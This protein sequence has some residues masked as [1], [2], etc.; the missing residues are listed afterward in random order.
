VGDEARDNRDWASAAKAYESALAASSTLA[1][2]W[3]QLG[4]ARKESGALESAEQAYRAALKL[5]PD[6]ADSH[7]QLGHL[8]KMS[9]RKAEAIACYR[10]AAETVEG[11]N[12]ALR[13]LA[14][15]GISGRDL[16]FRRVENLAT[17]GFGEFTQGP[18]VCDVTAY[19]NA[20]QAGREPSLP[21]NRDWRLALGLQELGLA[22]PAV[23]ATE[24]GPYKALRAVG[25]R[26]DRES[27]VETLD[28]GSDCAPGTVIITTVADAPETP[29]GALSLRAG[30]QKHAY[31]I[32]VL[33]PDLLPGLANS[34]GSDTATYGRAA[35]ASLIYVADFECEREWRRRLTPIGRHP[36]IKVLRVST[37]T[38]SQT[39]PA[40][41]ARRV[42]CLRPE[43]E[44]ETLA[45]VAGVSGADPD[46]EI[47]ISSSATNPQDAWGGNSL[48][49][50]CSDPETVFLAPASR[51][52]G[53]LWLEAAESRG[54]TFAISIRRASHST[55]WPPASSVNY[56]DTFDPAA[57]TRWLENP[58][59]RA[60]QPAMMTAMIEAT[61]REIRG[62][63]GDKRGVR[64]WSAPHAVPG[65]FYGFRS[66]TAPPSF[67]SDIFVHSAGDNAGQ[68]TFGPRRIIFAITEP[69]Q[70]EHRISVLV[71]RRDDQ[72]GS[73]V[74]RAGTWVASSKIDT[75]QDWQWITF[76]LPRRGNDRK[77]LTVEIEV[78]GLVGSVAIY[79]FVVYPR[80]Q[81]RLWF[82]FLDRA[83]RGD[84]TEIGPYLWAGTLQ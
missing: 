76:E 64:R 62:G 61:A 78:E 28:L 54:L 45:I 73:L 51:S 31:A 34:A 1:H 10:D 50:F 5:D 43:L 24:G 22:T 81:D 56:V 3:V 47:V 63:F 69:R 72:G 53:M 21:A 67:R 4:H 58:Q 13:E 44:D 68:M 82:E 74:A 77:P 14:A 70:D 83:S 48:E 23:Q 26:L 41:I 79:G 36:E 18:F 37:T 11:S 33:F 9:G 29:N 57:V 17:H 15:L 27:P 42:I 35:D 49:L 2:I 46:C 30:A 25:A 52:D 7:L 80:N 6:K 40:T 66:H 71:E 38:L 12:D 39:A 59:R 19:W 20:M 8:L 55:A 65:Q 75:L 16:E 60:T 32:V 84:V